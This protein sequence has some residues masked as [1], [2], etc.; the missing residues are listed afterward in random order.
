MKEKDTGKIHQWGM[1]NAS[2]A[3]KNAVSL[4]HGPVSK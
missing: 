4:I 1:E 3:C 2:L